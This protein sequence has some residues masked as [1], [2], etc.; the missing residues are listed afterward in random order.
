MLVPAAVIRELGL[1]DEELFAYA[2][3]TDWSL[4]ARE[5]GRTLLVVPEARV[6][7]EVSAATGGEGSEAAL[8]YSVR[9]LLVVCERHAPLG[10]LRTWR[11][12][13]VVIGAHLVQALRGA[14]RK[15]GVLAVKRGWRDFRRGRLGE[16]RPS[17]DE[18][19]VELLFV[20]RPALR[21]RPALPED[22][23][24]RPEHGPVGAADGAE[25]PAR[26]RAAPPHELPAGNDAQPPEDERCRDVPAD[27]EPAVLDRVE[28]LEHA[29]SLGR[30]AAPVTHDRT[31]ARTSR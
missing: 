26:P 10:L 19:A 5:S 24:Q 9:N 8:Y 31:G 6:A 25:M 18:Q 4:R 17:G 2:E 7:H 21:D 28:E 15:R 23:R 3:D 12:R 22:P 1:F 29:Q 13:G 14:R 30:S 20:E 11:R 16:Y 27:Q